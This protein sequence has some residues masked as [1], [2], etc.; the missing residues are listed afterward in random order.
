MKFNSTVLERKVINEGYD[1]Q[2][3]LTRTVE[4][5][6]EGKPNPEVEYSYTLC[7]IPRICTASTTCQACY[8]WNNRDS[9]RNG[10]S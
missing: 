7:L 4:A 2:L 10:V 1:R 6:M 8:V 5:L 9:H 3:A